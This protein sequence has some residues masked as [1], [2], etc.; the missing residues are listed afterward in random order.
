VAEEKE[1][2]VTVTNG[3]KTAGLASAP[4]CCLRFEDVRGPRVAEGAPLQDAQVSVLARCKVRFSEPVDASTLAGAFF[5]SGGAGVTGALFCNWDCS[6]SCAG[7]ASTNA[8]CFK[9]AQPLA[10]GTSY[11]CVV[12]DAVK[13]LRGHRLENAVDGQVRWSFTTRCQGC[14]NP[15]LGDIAAASGFTS[16][17]KYK[18]YSVTGQPTPVGT[19]SSASYKLQS[20]FIYSSQE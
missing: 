18:L 1:V 13:D 5:I 7:L 4:W 8:A 2:Q 17:A 16:S 10:Y 14:G 11:Q 20:G 15:W 19:A 6:A 9:P 3:G 12:T